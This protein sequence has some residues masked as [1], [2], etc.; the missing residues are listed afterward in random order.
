MGIMTGAAGQ[1]LLTLLEAP[2]SRQADS[3]E[4]NGVRRL[5]LC[6]LLRAMALA[7]KFVE[8]RRG[9]ACQMFHFNVAIAARIHRRDMGAAGAVAGFTA[10]P[11]EPA[12]RRHGIVGNGDRV[13]E[14]ALACRLLRE[15]AAHKLRSEMLLP[16]RRIPFLL[17]RKIAGAQLHQ[18]C[19]VRNKDIAHAG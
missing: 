5:V 8:A 6:L 4:P 3:L 2:A 16:R 11:K 18:L 15:G 7:A 17:M 14:K 13:T 12:L 19:V 1:R 9:P 10:H